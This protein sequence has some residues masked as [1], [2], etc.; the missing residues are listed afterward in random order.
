LVDALE[1]DDFRELADPV[2]QSRYS[3]TEMRRM[4]EAAASCIRH[5]VTKR[6]RMVQ[7]TICRTV[8]TTGIREVPSGMKCV[9]LVL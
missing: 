3:K 8:S 7:V 6:P 1:T 2:L 5:S 4:V 9:F